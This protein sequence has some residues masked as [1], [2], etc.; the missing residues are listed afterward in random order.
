MNPETPSRRDRDQD[1]LR[2]RFE[3]YYGPVSFYFN[4][5][6]FSREDSHDLAQDTFV[7]A[8]RGLGGFRGDARF[9]SWLFTIAKNVGSNETRAQQ[10]GKRSGRE[11]D[12]DALGTESPLRDAEGEEES[13]A[14]K[15]DYALPDAGPDPLEGL[16]AVEQRE[17]LREALGGLPDRMR[18]TVYLRVYQELTYREIAEILKVSIQTV[19]SQLHQARQRLVSILS[20]QFSDLEHPFEDSSLNDSSG[21]ES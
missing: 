10:A 2:E 8:Y 19:K 9:K 15:G 16:L 5:L 3:R 11:I 18:R 1:R 12:L 14:E 4:R 20:A 21:H 17:L 13:R 7:R 6:G